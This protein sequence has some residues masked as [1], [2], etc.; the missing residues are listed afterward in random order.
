MPWLD[1]LS[2][3]R[4]SQLQ[5]VTRAWNI[6]HRGSERFQVT[7]CVGETAHICLRPF[8]WKNVFSE[9]KILQLGRTLEQN[10]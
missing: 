1:Q 9:K 4:G 5:Q 8:A 7:F 10:F 6:L 3:L 2:G